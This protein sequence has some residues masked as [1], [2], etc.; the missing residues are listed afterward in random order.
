MKNFVVYFARVLP[1][2]VGAQEI[3]NQRGICFSVLAGLEQTIIS[4]DR[5]QIITRCF[6]DAL[7][8]CVTKSSFT[9]CISEVNETS[10]SALTIASNNFNEAILG[11]ALPGRRQAWETFEESLLIATKMNRQDA[12]TQIV[13]FRQILFLSLNLNDLNR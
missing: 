10:V 12:D 9:Q 13:K 7:D 4:N 3:L 11:S 5:E 1:N 8:Q 6:D 2:F